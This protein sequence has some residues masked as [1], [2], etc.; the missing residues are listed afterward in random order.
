VNHFFFRKKAQKHFIFYR[1]YLNQKSIKLL[2]RWQSQS[3]SNQKEIFGFYFNSSASFG[4][5]TPGAPIAAKSAVSPFC[6]IAIAVEVRSKFKTGPGLITCGG[7]IIARPTRICFS[8]NSKRFIDSVASAAAFT[9]VYSTKPTS[10]KL[11]TVLL[12]SF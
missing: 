4:K 7:G 3:K 2:K 6:V 10:K 5:A 9:V 8:F 1:F 11:V 12:S